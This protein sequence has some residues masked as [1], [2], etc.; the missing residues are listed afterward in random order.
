MQ[1]I[2]EFAQCTK[3]GR[4]NVSEY[5]SC[6]ISFLGSVVVFEIH[7]GSVA[8]NWLILQKYR[9]N[10]NCRV[11]KSKI[12]MWHWFLVLKAMK[13]AKWPRTFCMVLTVWNGSILQSDYLTSCNFATMDTCLNLSFSII[14]S[15]EMDLFQVHFTQVAIIMKNCKSWII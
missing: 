2:N 3:S 7:M 8:Q 4:I 1:C 14:Y 6:Y 13:A 9:K 11:S 10:K 5:P 15:F 12:I